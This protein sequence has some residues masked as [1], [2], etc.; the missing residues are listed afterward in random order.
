MSNPVLVHTYRG[1]VIENMHR[2][3]IAVCDPKGRLI[4]ACGDAERLIY[5]RSAIKA[6][7]AIPLIETGTADHFKLNDAELAIS[8]SSH[9]AE[10]M[11][12]DTVNNFLNR[13][14]LDDSALEC[15]ASAPL[16]NLTAENLLRQQKSPRKI[17]N[18]C[19][20]K[21]TAMLACASFLGESTQGYIEREH[22][23]QQRWLDTLGE[24]ADIDMHRLPWNRDGC[25]IPVVAMPLKSIATAAAR[26]AAPD[27]CS[28]NRIDSVDRIASAIA[29]APQMIGGSDTLDTRVMQ[30]TG[31]RLMIKGGAAG[32]YV[33]A[34][35]DQNLGIALKI[36][37]GNGEASGIALLELL[38]QLKI[39]HPDDLDKLTDRLHIPQ[40]NT[41]DFLTGYQQ[42][43]NPL[44]L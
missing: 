32:V 4:K 22:P 43:V 9:N 18:N 3:T 29:A 16:H 15:G 36:D 2:G 11:H 33:A 28:A 31:R 6:L 44:P 37:D 41:R 23:T 38:K 8:C 21:H 40:H 34:I 10:P 35:P 7:Q 39:L 19:S 27:Q 1:E 30:I 26:F 13:L 14:N 20:G 24:M 17:H 25:G 42:A 5:P 12:I